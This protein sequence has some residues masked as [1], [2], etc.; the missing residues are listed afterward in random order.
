METGALAGYQMVDV[1]ATL[2]NATFHDT[3]SNEVAFKIAASMAFKAAAQ[4]AQPVLLE[5]ISKL[6]VLTPEEF[7]GTV[8]GDLNSR[9]GKVASMTSRGKTQII[10]GEVPLGTMFGYATDLRSITQGRA[11]FTMLPSHYSPVP[12]KLQDEILVRLGRK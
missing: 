9:R 3:D 8:I 2:L 12:L 1:K 7:M 6:E 5:P 4:K 11:T 10:H